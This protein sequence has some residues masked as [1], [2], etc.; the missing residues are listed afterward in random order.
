MAV[1]SNGKIMIA[2]D[3]TATRFNADATLD[4]GYST[5]GTAQAL[6][7]FPEHRDLFDRTAN[8][9]FEGG[10]AVVLPTARCVADIVLP[11]P[12][13][14]CNTRFGRPLVLR[15]I[16]AQPPSI[17]ADVSLS[18][19]GTLTITGTAANEIVTSMRTPITP[20]GCDDRRA[21][22]LLADR[23]G[24]TRQRVARRRR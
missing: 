20:R 4:S 14:N 24:P 5:D 18:G 15:K 9:N 6:T 2:G 13:F 7:L 11:A 12:I 8:T 23:L 3:G 1:L 21:G 22:L 17:D 16:L 19:S 10:D